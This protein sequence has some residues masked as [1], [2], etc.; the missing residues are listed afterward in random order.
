MQTFKTLNSSALSIVIADSN[1]IFLEGL[2]VAAEKYCSVA[3][4]CCASNLDELCMLL[5]NVYCDVIVCDV[6]FLGS[7]FENICELK[8]RNNKARIIALNSCINAVSVSKAMQSGCDGYLL[9]DTNCLE[10][11]QAIKT[12]LDFRKYISP[13]IAAAIESSPYDSYN[14][15]LLYSFVTDPRMREML[16]LICYGYTSKQIATRLFVSK[17]SIDKYRYDLMHAI[18]AKNVSGIILFALKY[19]IN[20]DIELQRKYSLD[21]LLIA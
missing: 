2:N 10:I 7:E 15:N 20:E 1:E 16:F 18:G 21:Y 4:R 6:H 17:K 19:K 14:A 5:D 13:K 9:K 3:R 8:K 12:V 11:A